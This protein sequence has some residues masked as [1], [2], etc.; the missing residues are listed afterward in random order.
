MC[1]PHDIKV[2]TTLHIKSLHHNFE[3]IMN[4]NRLFNNNYNSV[5][6]RLQMAGNSS[7]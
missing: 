1:K 3:V 2:Y 4:V 7:A 6:V 5:Q